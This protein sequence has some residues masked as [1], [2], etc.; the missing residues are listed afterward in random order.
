MAALGLPA[1]GSLLAAAQV[2][3]SGSF[4]AAH[5]ARTVAVAPGYYTPSA[6][7]WFNLSVTIECPACSGRSVPPHLAD[8]LIV[9]R[10]LHG[11]ANDYHTFP[12]P[13]RPDPRNVSA[14]SADPPAELYN[15]TERV[16][17]AAPLATAPCATAADAPTP[18]SES[19]SR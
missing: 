13:E 14:G 18:S 5:V 3:E 6:E 19:A 7:A 8:V 9:T 12:P 17:P 11:G 2:A 16:P 4:R 10:C 1:C 15:P